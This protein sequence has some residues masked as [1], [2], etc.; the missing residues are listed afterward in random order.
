MKI[1]MLNWNSFGKEDLREAFEAFGHS[2]SIMTLVDGEDENPGTIERLQKD[3]E[4]CN[5]DIV[6]TFNY[7]PSVA[8]ACKNLA[9]TYLSWVYD[10]PHVRMYHYSIIYPTNHIFTFDK[11]QYL[12]FATKGIDTVHYLPMAVNANRLQKAC[13]IPLKETDKNPIEEVSFV[14]SLYTEEHNFYGRL[15]NIKPY[16]RGYL[17]GLIAAQKEV[18]GFNFIEQLLPKDVISDMQIDLPM[19]PH[20]GGVETVEYLF[21]QYVIDREITARERREYL[22]L[23]GKNFGVNLYTMDRSVAFEGCQNLGTLD[24]YEEAP[25][26]FSKS[27]INLNITLRS[28]L[29]GIPLRSF[30]IMGAGGFLMTNYQ[31]EYLELFNPGDEFVFYES[32]EDLVEK[33]AYYKEHESERREI[34]QN[35]LLRVMKDHSYE[36]RV[37]LMLEYV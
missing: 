12:Y 30:E 15:K 34:A 16:T 33:I 18:W 28:I 7:Y 1:C 26:V 8:I 9:I 19:Q 11:A 14:G 20:A 25:K 23:V 13:K 2:V 10:S 17:E 5:V 31:E 37:Q 6:F 36:N 24:Y 27:K 22:E 32:K 3:L 21:A 4:C 35:G 29:T